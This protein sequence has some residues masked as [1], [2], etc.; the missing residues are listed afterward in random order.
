MVKQI[1]KSP[2]F[3][4]I[5]EDLYSN[6]VWVKSLAVFIN[7]SINKMD[8]TFTAETMLF[9]TTAMIVGTR[10][11]MNNSDL[12]ES[13]DTQQSP[14]VPE[15]HDIPESHPKKDI[16]IAPGNLQKEMAEL[17]KNI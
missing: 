3:H 17:A 13:Q 15:K 16:N 10:Y 6:D 4:G 8:V 1:D 11:M 7:N 5:F 14:G 9:S 2:K 12:G